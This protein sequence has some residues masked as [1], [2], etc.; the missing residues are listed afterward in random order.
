MCC[1]F[2]LRLVTIET[3]EKLD[4]MVQAQVRELHPRFLRG[5]ELNNK[6]CRRFVEQQQAF[7]RGRV[8]TW[9]SREADLVLHEQTS[10]HLLV[11][12]FDVVQPAAPR[13][14]RAR[15]F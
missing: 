1:S 14:Q 9:I 6:V 7:L 4:C 5:S 12:G 8:A 2:G 13:F 3:K 10:Q 11:L 15:Q